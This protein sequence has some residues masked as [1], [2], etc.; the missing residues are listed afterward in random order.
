MVV[1]VPVFVLWWIVLGARRILH[2][3]TD[4]AHA[5]DK[6]YLRSLNT[7]ELTPRSFCLC[8]NG[9]PGESSKERMQSFLPPP[10]PLRTTPIDHETGLL[11]T[12]DGLP[13][14]PPP[15]LSSP[16]PAENRR[17]RDQTRGAFWRGGGDLALFPVGGGGV[18]GSSPADGGDILCSPCRR[19][20]AGAGAGGRGGLGDHGVRF[21]GDMLVLRVCT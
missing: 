13:L 10:P 3:T 9:V 19:G 12:A 17:P 15:P 5:P 6:N 21:L 7:S 8:R 16:A 14:T 18:L 11:L 20:R 2:P 4:G 1:G